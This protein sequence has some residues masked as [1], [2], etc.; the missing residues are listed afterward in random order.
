MQKTEKTE[1]KKLKKIGENSIKN[2]IKEKS[3]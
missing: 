1:K 2:S 3:R